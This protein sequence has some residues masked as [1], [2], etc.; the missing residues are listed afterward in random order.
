MRAGC[1]GPAFVAQKALLTHGVTLLGLTG[2]F[3]TPRGPAGGVAADGLKHDAIDRAHGQAQLATGT[4]RLDHSVHAFVGT[5]NR[6]NWTNVNAARATDAP[7][8]VHV[9]SLSGTLLAIF[10]I[11]LQNRFAGQRGKALY[12]LMAT[13]RALVDGTQIVSNRLGVGRAVGIS[14]SCALGLRQHRQDA[15]GLWTHF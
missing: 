14:A 3:M 5:H 12:T 13:R 1:G 7:V 10:G 11:E 2:Q 8:L 9:G 6:I 4:K 15:G